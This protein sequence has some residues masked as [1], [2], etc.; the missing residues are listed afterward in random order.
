MYLRITPQHDKFSTKKNKIVIDNT[1]IQQTHTDLYSN[2][3]SSRIDTACSAFRWRNLLTNHHTQF[4]CQIP[5]L[6]SRKTKNNYFMN[7]QYPNTDDNNVKRKQF[8]NKRSS[9]KKNQ[10]VHTDSIHSVHKT[11]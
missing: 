11:I 4:V 2:E 5:L 1:P 3:T 6:S 7:T 9:D 10:S 8:R